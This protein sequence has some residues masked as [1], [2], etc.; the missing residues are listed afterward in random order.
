M[1]PQ[2][3]KALVRVPLADAVALRTTTRWWLVTVD[4]LVLVPLPRDGDGGRAIREGAP[5]CGCGR[6]VYVPH[7]WLASRRRT[8]DVG[9]L[10][11]VAERVLRVALA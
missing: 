10:Q 8:T 3:G 7:R 5:W 1:P 9:R 4:G 6:D 2:T 11:S